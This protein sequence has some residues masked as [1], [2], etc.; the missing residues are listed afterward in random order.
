MGMGIRWDKD[1]DGEGDRDRNGDEDEHGN[2][3]EDKDEVGQKWKKK[4][5]SG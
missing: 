2:E 4:G 5:V 1:E 3:G